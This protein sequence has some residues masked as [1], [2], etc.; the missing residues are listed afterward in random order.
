MAKSSDKKRAKD[1]AERA[2]KSATDGHEPYV[3]G[4][5]GE[6]TEG[7][8]FDKID[9][10]SSAHFRGTPERKNHV[11]QCMRDGKTA[12]MAAKEVG[13]DR[14]TIFKSWLKQDAAFKAAWDEAL[15][16]GAEFY[17]DEVRRRATEGTL[18]P[19]YQQG[20]LVGHIREFSDPLLIMATKARL[21]EKY[22]DRS[23]VKQTGDIHIHLDDVDGDA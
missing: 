13:V 10:L 23:D 4:P 15:E 16:E 18:K 5:T 8:Q 1:R 14:S 21:P 6:V 19:V 3:P 20:E 2:K 9:A 12:K 17:E 11:L 22:R 7:V